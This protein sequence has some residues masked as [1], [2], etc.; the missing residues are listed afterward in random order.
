M[1]TYVSVD[2]RPALPATPQASNTLVHFGLYSVPIPIFIFFPLKTPPLEPIKT[3]VSPPS[4]H[5]HQADSPLGYRGR[6]TES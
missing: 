5:H 4:Y 6:R 2:F 3:K 1:N